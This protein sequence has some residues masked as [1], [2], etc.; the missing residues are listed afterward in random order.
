MYGKA[1]RDCD[2]FKYLFLGSKNIKNFVCKQARKKMSFQLKKKI[3]F[4]QWHNELFVSG[5]LFIYRKVLQIR[6]T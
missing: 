5:F 6:Q 3:C 4:L 2:F 1:F